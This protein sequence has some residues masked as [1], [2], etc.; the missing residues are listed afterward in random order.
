MSMSL[1]SR[2]WSF[3]LFLSRFYQEIY[4][5]YLK[6]P[7]LKMRGIKEK[8]SDE[9]G[10]IERHAKCASFMYHS[11]EYTGKPAS[12]HYQHTCNTIHDGIVLQGKRDGNM[13]II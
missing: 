8:N 11:K 4:T 13:S 3:Q 12:T 9:N 6:V 7:L 5:Y 2:R 10:A 1:D